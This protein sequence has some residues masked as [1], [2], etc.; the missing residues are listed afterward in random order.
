VRA[1]IGLLMS[2]P[3]IPQAR[4]GRE[5]ACPQCGT[6]VAQKATTCFFCG[7]ALNEVPRRR[8]RV[9]W[10]DLLL[11]AVIGTVVAI[12][13]LRPPSAPA[14]GGV[15]QVARL[16]VVQVPEKI[17][18][19]PDVL[20]MDEIAPAT[21]TPTPTS[22]PSDTPQPTPTLLAEPIRHKVVKGDTIAAIAKQ[23]NA[24]AKDIIQ[25]NSL[26]ADGKL[27]IGKEL[28][29]PV[30]GPMGGPGPTATPSKDTLV[31]TVQSGDTISGIAQRFGSQIDWILQANKM[32]GTEFLRIGQPLTVPR[33]P[34]TP[35]PAPT[36]EVIPVTP[37]PTPVP[38][39][40]APALLTPADGAVLTGQDHVLLSWTSVGILQPDQWYVVT[41]KKNESNTAAVTWW[42]KG[43]TWLLGPEH[44]GT[45]QAG[46][47]F[48]WRVQVRAGSSEQPGD[49][50]S[51][52]SADR[53]FTWR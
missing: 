18:P 9:P 30:A 38:G 45:T 3:D 5:R 43:T 17:V 14:G 34:A 12:W 11:F 41:L 10:A 33:T 26:S 31:Y 50:A 23:Y 22:A 4:Y 24:V 8:L 35:T 13:W 27:S 21:V 16:G 52:A 29:I 20:A 44:R 47:D 40:R 1:R 49:A 42:T 6:R 48:T 37:S 46:V 36:V 28:I 53:R 39:L 19:T 7:A 15:A 2:Q 51:P 32:K 25:A